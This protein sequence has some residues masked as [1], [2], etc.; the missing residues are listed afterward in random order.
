MRSL[1]ERDQ[2]APGRLL[3]VSGGYGFSGVKLLILLAGREFRQI[4]D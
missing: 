1:G 4:S 2:A 3:A